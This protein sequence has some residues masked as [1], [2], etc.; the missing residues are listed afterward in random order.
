MCHYQ[1]G[2]VGSWLKTDF[3]N[4]V[5]KVS[6]FLMSFEWV[7][8]L[9]SSKWLFQ[10][11]VK[12]ITSIAGCRKAT[13]LPPLPVCTRFAT[14]LCSDSRQGAQGTESGWAL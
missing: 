14:S 1:C 4:P 5:T 10:Y 6:F 11:Q 12:N 13:I 3:F 7:E 8:I 2:N 9:S